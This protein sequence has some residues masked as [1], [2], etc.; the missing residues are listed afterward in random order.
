MREWLKK[1]IKQLSEND[2]ARRAGKTFA[3]AFISVLVLG[4]FRLDKS[5]LIAAGAAGIS[6]GWNYLKTL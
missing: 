5:T 6:A 2:I 4:G 3:Q 1:T